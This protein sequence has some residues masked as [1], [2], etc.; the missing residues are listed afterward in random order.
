MLRRTAALA[1]LTLAAALAAVTTSAAEAA[2]PTLVVPDSPSGDVFVTATA[3]PA[4]APYLAVRLIRGASPSAPYEGIDPAP[5]A[6]LGGSVELSV[7]SWG[8]DRESAS[9][10]LLACANEDP[11]TCAVQLATQVR[12]IEQ[13]ARTSTKFE[14]PEAD[15]VFVPEDDV[16]VTSRNDGGGVLRAH[17]GGI[18]I[19]PVEVEEQTLISGVRTKFTAFPDIAYD[20][21]SLVVKRC[22]ALHDIYC[23]WATSTPISFI[24]RPSIREMWDAYSGTPMTVDPRWSGS[25][26][27]FDSWVLTGG[28]PYALSWAARDSAGKLVA[29]GVGAAVNPARAAGHALPNGEYTVTFTATVTRGDV[30]KTDSTSRPLTI[31]NDPPRQEARLLTAVRKVYP[32]AN[33]AVDHGGGLFRVAALSAMS[34]DYRDG[35]FRLR[36][37]HGRIVHTRFLEEPCSNP[38]RCS[39][40]DA[41]DVR[42]LRIRKPGRYRA[43]LT[44]PDQW[45]RPTTKDLG[46][47]YVMQKGTARS[48]VTVSG[49]ASRLS[50]YLYRARV[51]ATRGELDMYDTP[52][53]EVFVRG[54]GRSTVRFECRVPSISLRWQRNSWRTGQ[55]WRHA[56]SYSTGGKSLSGRTI[57][58]RVYGKGGGRF[59]MQQIRVMHV[60]VVWRMPK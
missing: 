51:P 21:A 4:T 59:R 34:I 12:R 52:F 6:N 48:A 9:F 43:E 56:C 23:T 37:S 8:L 40:T 39:H 44:Y 49:S 18:M 29:E 32:S 26:R 30:V 7:P 13:T 14:L 45:G 16:Y 5:T 10:V 3:D 38:Q 24:A 60:Y 47:V 22:S 25:T 53:V 1:A 15:P 11:A 36:D 19:A 33:P 50:R 42:D 28:A 41:W 20:G 27:H 54:Q 35:R 31:A 58:V 46:A 17:L 57:Q 2:D 55:T